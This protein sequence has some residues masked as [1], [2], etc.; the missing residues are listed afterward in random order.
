MTQAHPRKI[1]W[2]AYAA[3]LTF[4]VVAGEAVNLSRMGW[5]TAVT[6]ANWAL[7]VALL[8]ALWSYALQR[9]L[10]NER[11]WRAVFWVVACANALMLVPVMMSGGMVALVTG[12]LTVLIVP[13]YVAA[14][15]YAYRSHQLWLAAG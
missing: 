5:P 1:G 4:A 9:P 3:M 10:G 14:Y 8:T 12:A 6:L 11:Y 15:R 2:L 7:T 13:A